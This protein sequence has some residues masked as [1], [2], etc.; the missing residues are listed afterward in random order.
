MQI[1][2]LD[3]LVIVSSPQDLALMVVKKALNMAE[4]MNIPVIG[5]FENM[6]YLIC[7]HCGER[8]EVFGPSK[9]GDVSKLTGVPLIDTLPLDRN[10]AEHCD[11]GSIE[12]YESELFK[13]LLAAKR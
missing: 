1:I 9:G 5:L 7:P 3:G 6:S 8:I 4:A 11:N 10:L 12:Q 2:P 13:K